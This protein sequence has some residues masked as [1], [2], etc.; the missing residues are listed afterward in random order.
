[1]NNENKSVRCAAVGALS[2]IWKDETEKALLSRDVD[3]V[4]PWLDPKDSIDN[5][6][7]KIVAEK[8]KMPEDEVRR[9]YEKLDEKIGLKLAWVRE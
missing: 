5:R 1:M 9:R 2:N 6:R 8:L 7:V 4:G 3:G